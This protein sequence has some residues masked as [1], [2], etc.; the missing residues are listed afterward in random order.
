MT[1]PKVSIVL[2]NYNYARYLEDRILSLLGQTFTDFELIIVDDA[3]TDDSRSIIERYRSNQHVR[4]LLFD[5]NSGFTY[6]R[7]NDGAAIATG[8]YI[9]FAGADDACAPT[10]VETLVRIL[11]EHPDVGVAYTR[12]WIINSA[13]ERIKKKP[14]GE[15]W[16]SDFIATAAEEIPFLLSGGSVQSASAAL[17]RRSVFDRCGGWDASFQLCADFLLWAQVLQISQLAYVAQPL[18]YFRWHETN[19]GATTRSDEAILEKYR[20]FGS[21]MRTFPVS[22]QV[23]HDTWNQLLHR[24]VTQL[25]TD[26]WNAN[27]KTVIRTFRV[28]N[29]VDPSF[30]RRL[31]EMAVNRI[32]RVFRRPK[33]ADAPN[34]PEPDGQPPASDTS[35]VAGN[36]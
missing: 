34:Q 3:S 33:K 20:V 35:C 11:D 28:A 7:W 24:W 16:S 31:S 1:S 8:E 21:I 23:R 29:D 13:G 22:P 26:G 14:W 32:F 15:R 18:N 9:M 2:P 12:S 10:L 4:T 6:R 17:L 36:K 27:F 30:Y 25:L 19:V 5:H